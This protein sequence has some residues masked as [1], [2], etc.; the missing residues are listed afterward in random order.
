[1]REKTVLKIIVMTYMRVMSNPVY[2]GWR[3]LQSNYMFSLEHQHPS[4]VEQIIIWSFSVQSVI[5]ICVMT[6][7]YL[8]FSVKS[9]QCTYT[10]NWSLYSKLERSTFHTFWFLRFDT[11]LSSPLKAPEAT[12]RMLVVSTGTL[13]PLSLRELFSGTFTTVPSN[14]FS[15]P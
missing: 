4:T 7:V 14:N 3:L 13:S 15:I 5:Q 10:S 11:I 8:T 12:N 2:V 6:K 1:M 9:K